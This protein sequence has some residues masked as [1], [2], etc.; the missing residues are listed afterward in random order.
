MNASF[1]HNRAPGA[2]L[3]KVPEAT[4]FFW[5][6][7][8]FS[9]TVGETAADYLNVDLGLGLDGTSLVMA[10]LLAVFL[11]LQVRARRYVPWRYWS[12]VVLVSVVGTLIT[13]Y[14]TDQL[15]VPLQTTS[16]VF[17]LALLAAFS[18]WY[19]FERTL[20]IHT[21]FT[22]RREAFY[23]TVILFTFA[24]GTALGDLLA[25]SLGLGLAS[26]ALLFGGAIAVVALAYFR[27]GLNGVAA[28]WA[29]YVL[30]RP[31]GASCGDLLT[32]PLQQGGL[33]LDAMLVNA[34][35]LVGIVALVAYLSITRCD[36]TEERGVA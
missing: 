2:L 14:L 3:N 11:A 8:V 19:L 6:I 22:R 34:V 26:S 16:L 33:G 30:T 15:G 9:T 5:I 7:K 12:T 31:L 27:L 36:V 28:F 1:A 24:L 32:Q 35:F 17:S 23:W 10:G 21:V 4:V 29:T 13:D 20:S 25:E 18:I